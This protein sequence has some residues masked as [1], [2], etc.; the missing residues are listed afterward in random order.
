MKNL[1]FVLGKLLKCNYCEFVYS[2]DQRSK[3]NEHLKLHTSDPPI[4]FESSSVAVG[5][6]DLVT[7]CL[8]QKTSEEFE[9]TEIVESTKLGAKAS[10]KKKSKSE[11]KRSLKKEVHG[12]PFCMYLI[13]A[14]RRS[15][16]VFVS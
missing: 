1:V 3:Y 14:A 6:E 5:N 16:L 9:E 15:L 8:Q 10:T 11:R 4:K 2:A 13:F 7:N 12:K